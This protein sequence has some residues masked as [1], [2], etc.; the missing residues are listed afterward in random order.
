LL[1]GVGVWLRGRRVCVWL[2]RLFS[3]FL[4]ASIHISVSIYPPPSSS[5]PV[6]FSVSVLDFLLVQSNITKP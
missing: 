4:P 6:Y 5:L 2:T 3:I 1:G